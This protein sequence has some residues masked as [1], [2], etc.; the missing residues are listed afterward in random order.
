MPL[1]RWCCIRRRALNCRRYS[2]SESCSRPAEDSSSQNLP[3]ALRVL[4]R[5]PA[6]RPRPDSLEGISRVVDPSGQLEKLRALIA[7]LIPGNAFYGR[8]LAV[9]GVDQ[10][11][12]SLEEFSRRMPFTTKRDL[13]EDQT[14]HPPYGTN[15]TFPLTDYT[16]FCQTSGTTA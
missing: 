12:V 11:V 15:H 10:D 2:W 3:Q 1:W 6:P 16:R 14:R 4:P 9:A 8:R 5:R 13:V 7:A